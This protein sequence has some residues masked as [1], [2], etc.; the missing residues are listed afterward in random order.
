MAYTKYQ[1]KKGIID[2]FENGD[3]KTL[4]KEKFINRTGWTTDGKKYYSD[5]LSKI[6][7]SENVYGNSNI[8]KITRVNSYNVDHDGDT[9]NDD[10]DKNNIK[11]DSEPVIA[12]KLFNRNLGDL[13]KIVGYE[14]PLK[15]SK[16]DKGLGKIDLISIKD[17]I[18]YLIELKKPSNDESILRAILE[19]QTYFE[20]LDSNK[21][22]NDF[23][24]NDNELKKA[25]LIFDNSKQHKMLKEMKKLTK[26]A[27]L[28]LL[29][30]LEIETY[31]ITALNYDDISIGKFNSGVKLN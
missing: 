18:I 24:F 25:I 2:F 7:I 30:I 31:I 17:E 5:I 4:Y 23:Q 3:L 26:S 15:N 28:E 27:T 11:K 12:K 8:D 13:G 20:Q 16:K 21:F 29:N 14:I 6:I 9:K 22:K 19:I 10:G 1:T